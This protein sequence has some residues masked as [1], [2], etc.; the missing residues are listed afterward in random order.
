MLALS[1]PSKTD[2]SKPDSDIGQHSKGE[3][4]Q[5]ANKQGSPSRCHSNQTDCNTGNDT[6]DSDAKQA[7]RLRQRR[8][9]RAVRQWKQQRMKAA[10]KRERAAAAAAAA[11]AK[12]ATREKEVSFLASQFRVLAT[13]I[14]RFVKTALKA[15]KARPLYANAGRRAPQLHTTRNTN[16][17]PVIASLRRTGLL[18]LK[19][20][21][22]PGSVANLPA[23][24]SEAVTSNQ[25]GSERS[26]TT[27]PVTPESSA[28]QLPMVRTGTVGVQALE[29]RSCTVL[30]TSDPHL[31]V[32]PA[33]EAHSSPSVNPGGVLLLAQDNAS[34]IAITPAPVAVTAIASSFEIAASIS[35]PKSVPLPPVDDEGWSGVE[36]TPN[37]TSADGR[38]VG[39]GQDTTGLSSFPIKG[40]RGGREFLPTRRKLLAPTLALPDY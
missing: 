7:T 5:S 10:E 31:H 6:D 12:A 24:A 35:A 20:L 22:R 30:E 2:S 38:T 13:N 11:R 15:V 27:A 28:V 40:G 8:Q 32:R 39:G 37:K 16:L 4:T 18:L 14:N 17:N 26:T 3:D 9:T 23:P 36:R 25:T 34:D 29:L 21:Q 33:S 19:F 1:W